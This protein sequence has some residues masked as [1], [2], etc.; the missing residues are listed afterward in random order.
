MIDSNRLVAIK[1]FGMLVAD[2][3][4]SSDASMK[5]ALPH[6]V[7]TMMRSDFSQ[8]IRLELGFQALP[9]I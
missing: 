5:W 4:D 2:S 1:A 7:T 6:F 9:M 3:L 8:G